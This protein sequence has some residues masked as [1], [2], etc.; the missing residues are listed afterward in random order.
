MKLHTRKRT[1]TT[2]GVALAAAAMLGGCG[3]D[4]AGSDVDPGN[5]AEA[6]SYEAALAE[7]P[8]DLARLYE[9]GSEL[10]EGGE[11]AYESTLAGVRGHPVVVN[12]WGSWCGPC[13]EEFPHLQS[14]AAEHLDEVAFLGIDIED[15]PDA[16]ETFLRDHP[17]PYPSV[18][19]P[20]REFV[21]WIDT[22]LIGQPNTLFYDEA[23]KLVYVKQG[24]YETEEDLAADIDRYALS[25]QPRA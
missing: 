2:V 22:P 11:D 20:D 24:P 16:Y 13:R 10:I 9:N 8:P 1:Q 25:G 19:D 21:N 15:S 12:T 18:A 14:Q 5:A 4:E 17:I 23:G 6:P 3:S 7:A